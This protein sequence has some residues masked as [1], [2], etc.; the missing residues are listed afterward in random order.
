MNLMKIPYNRYF[1]SRSLKYASLAARS[2][3]CYVRICVNTRRTHVNNKLTVSIKI[4]LCFINPRP[5]LGLTLA[6]RGSRRLGLS[7]RVLLSLGFGPLQLSSRLRR[8]PGRRQPHCFSRFLHHH[9]RAGFYF[10]GR[11]SVDGS[12]GGSMLTSPVR[13]ASGTF[14][15]VAVELEHCLSLCQA[16]RKSNGSPGKAVRAAQVFYFLFRR[17]GRPL[18]SASHSPGRRSQ[19]PS[20]REKVFRMHLGQMS[21]VLAPL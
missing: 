17:P 7:A 6:F 3:F 5:I 2:P 14:V 11:L 1:L 12:E 21:C 4:I 8:W 16:V 15:L 18:P 20:Q 13:V 9:H 19:H 10:T